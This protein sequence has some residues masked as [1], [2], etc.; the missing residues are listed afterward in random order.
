MTEE[1]AKT[2]WCP[3]ARHA[4]STDRFETNPP[5]VS[6]NRMLEKEQQAEGCNCIGSACMAWRWDMD[7]S[8]STEE[9]HGGDLVLRLKRLRGQPKQGFCGLAGK[10]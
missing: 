1:E 2:K 8:S 6:C 3:Y 9:G 5:A 7:W 10:P 4:Y